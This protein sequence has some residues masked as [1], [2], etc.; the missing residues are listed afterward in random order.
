MSG[1][2]GGF[3]HSLPW[4]NIQNPQTPFFIMSDNCLHFNLV[5]LPQIKLNIN[6]WIWF[7]IC[8][9]T[10]KTDKFRVIIGIA[11]DL[12]TMTLS[13]KLIFLDSHFVSN[14]FYF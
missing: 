13:Y 7:K 1:E 3:Q 6:F 14:F 11:K 10:T 5:I 12:T 9:G 8:I 4:K 2:P